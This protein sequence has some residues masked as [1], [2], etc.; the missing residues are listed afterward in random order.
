MKYNKKEN[1]K[2]LVSICLDKG[3]QNYYKFIPWYTKSNKNSTQYTC[4]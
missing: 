1:A 2:Y 4:I 3:E